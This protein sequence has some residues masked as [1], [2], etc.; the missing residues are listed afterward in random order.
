MDTNNKTPAT[1]IWKDEH[2][3][4][5]VCE[6]RG[7]YDRDRGRHEVIRLGVFGSRADAKAAAKA[8]IPGPSCIVRSAAQ[9]IFA[10]IS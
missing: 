4:G 2:T 7:L 10:G 3:E 9:R 5:W 6:V 8:W 1:N